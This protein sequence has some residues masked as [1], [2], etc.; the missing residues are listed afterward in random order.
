MV[1]NNLKESPGK[2]ERA[3]LEEVAK[4]EDADMYKGTCQL[5]EGDGGRQLMKRYRIEI[6]ESLEK[7]LTNRFQKVLDHPVL[8]AMAMFNHAKW[9]GTE[10]EIKITFTDKLELL[11]K[12]YHHFFEPDETFEM[13]NDQ[14]VEMAVE[15][16]TEPSLMALK[17]HDLWAR[18]LMLSSDEYPLVLRLVVISL[19]VPAD[20]SESERIFSLMNDIK[21]AER[22]RMGQRNLKNLML[23][24]RMAKDL[25]AQDVPVM[26]ILKEFRAMAGEQGRRPHHAQNPITY[27]Y[28]KHRV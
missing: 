4:D 28:E 17:Y 16:L 25:K 23:W 13:V 8:N 7:H 3:F 24:H 20:T 6:I 18:K 14:W 1:L 15:I 27:E 26:A 5:Y 11:Y 9:P 19:I 2:A 22:A 10:A 12:T 21:T